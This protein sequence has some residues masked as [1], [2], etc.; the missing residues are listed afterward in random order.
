MARR[1]KPKTNGTDER[2]RM[3]EAKVF[4][5][6]EWLEIVLLKYYPGDRPEVP[7]ELLESETF[8]GKNIEDLNAEEMQRYERSRPVPVVDP[9]IDPSEG[10]EQPTE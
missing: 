5:L 8:A 3:S 4:H 7:A 9:N 2:P 1:P 6:L 10:T